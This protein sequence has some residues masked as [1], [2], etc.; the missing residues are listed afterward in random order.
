MKALPPVHRERRMARDTNHRIGKE[1]FRRRREA[2]HLTGEPG[3]NQ[4][5][6]DGWKVPA[7]DDALLEL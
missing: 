6:D 3:G 1:V 7:T 4:S 2:R 5:A